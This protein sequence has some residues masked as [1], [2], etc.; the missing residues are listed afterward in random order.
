MGHAP[1]SPQLQARA[2]LLRIEDTRRDEPALIDSLL[3]CKDG[4][5]RAGAA[6]TVGRIGARIHL[7]ALRR[8]ATDSDSSVAASA[9]FSLGLLK[10]TAS[11]SLAAL[12]LHAPIPV[13]VEAA[14]LLGELGDHG[15]A[16]IVAGLADPGLGSHAR[17]ALLLA[18]TRLRPVPAAA[19]APWLQSRD[20]AIAWR[21]AYAIARGRSVAAARLLLQQSTSPWAPVREQVARGA[22]RAI[23]GDSLATLA[24][25]ALARLAADTSARV[26][27]N[28]VRAVSS[29][30]ASARAAVVTALA[31][32]DPGVRLVAAQSL[33]SV[34]DTV[35]S[36]WIGPFDAETSFVFR[37]AIADAA[38]RHGINLATR[39]GWTAS[40]DWHRRAAAAELDGAGAAEASERRMERWSRDPD[41][42]VRAAAAAAY[43]TLADSGSVRSVVRQRLRAMLLDADVGVRRA[44]LAGLSRGA[45]PDDLAVALASYRISLVD[46]DNDARLAFWHLADTVLARHVATLPDSVTTRLATILRPLDPLERNVAA[47][48]N[49]FASWRD[50]LGTARPLAWYEERARES[51]LPART[52][53]IVTERGAMELRLLTADAPLTVYNLVTL[54]EQ[55]YFGGQRFHRVVPN[56]VV[57]GGDPRG[58][59]NGGPGYAIRDELNRRR[60]GRGVLGMALSGPNTGGSQFFVTH[61]PQPHLDGGYTVF[62]ELLE[63]G[64]VLDRIIQGDRIVRV[65]VH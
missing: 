31:D 61:S 11:A 27:T 37:R 19:I 58:D 5:S 24:R 55:G 3:S 10:D 32:P 54:A 42:R 56:F 13:A 15:R 57:Q 17:G 47:R 45:S 12:A 30:G 4:A 48:I 8:L 39:A 35:A 33:A 46:G 62:G 23:A 51:A 20:S 40:D 29:F 28:A 41:G 14:W 64:D 43:A 38:I 18:A 36:S 50:S 7:A 53:T 1:L 25:E 60:Y 49:R 16:A 21:A 44:S 2:R 63:G 52:V 6:L 26:R 65:T 9:L 59:G 22:T 34:L